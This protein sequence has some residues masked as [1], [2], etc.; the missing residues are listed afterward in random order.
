[1]YSCM[2]DSDC[3]VRGTWYQL[4]WHMVGLEITLQ[5]TCKDSLKVSVWVSR[6]CGFFFRLGCGFVSLLSIGQISSV[7]LI[8]LISWQF[9]NISYSYCGWH[10][11]PVIVMPIHKYIGGRTI[12]EEL[13]WN[14]SAAVRLID[15]YLI[16]LRCNFIWKYDLY[17]S[18]VC[19]CFFSAYTIQQLKD[20]TAPSCLSKYAI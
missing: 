9:V 16:F 8:H 13:C 14:L 15:I 6:I 2:N 11:I 10:V 5:S 19:H 3:F 18:C 17:S 1:M 20:F 7:A 4:L 12:S